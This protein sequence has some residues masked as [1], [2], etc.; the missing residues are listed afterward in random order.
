[1]KTSQCGAIMHQVR[2]DL[3]VIAAHAAD[4]AG[5]KGGACVAPA[6]H[7]DAIR[8]RIESISRALADCDRHR[9]PCGRCT[10]GVS[11]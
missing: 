9:R 3:M 8:A 4:L 2:N 11:L 7:H 5:R 1:M 10:H 6:C